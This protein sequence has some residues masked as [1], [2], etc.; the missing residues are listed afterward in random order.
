MTQPDIWY[1]AFGPDKD[2]D[3]GTTEPC[4]RS[5]RTFKSEI[6]AKLFAMQILA[7]GWTASAGTINPHQPK[8]VVGASEIE[9]WADSCLAGRY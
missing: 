6:D 7:K 5:T 9:R 4:A 8:C 2:A 3:S 1:V